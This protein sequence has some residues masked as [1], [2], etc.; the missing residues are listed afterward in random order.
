MIKR[1]D[2]ILNGKGGVGKSYDCLLY[3]LNQP[4]KTAVG[5]LVLYKPFLATAAVWLDSAARCCELRLRFCIR[6]PCPAL[7]PVQSPIPLDD[8]YENSVGSAET[9]LLVQRHRITPTR[10]S[11]AS[12]PSC[13]FRFWICFRP[14]G[15]GGPGFFDQP[16]YYHEQGR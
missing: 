11:W 4:L 12:P 8:Y 1:L 10:G 3:F 13:G 15:G 9:P 5:R 2:L 14:E 7:G 16:D 6:K